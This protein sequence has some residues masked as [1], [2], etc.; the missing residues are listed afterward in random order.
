MQGGA[1][2][3]GRGSPAI[4]APCTNTES[5]IFEDRRLQRDAGKDSPCSSTDSAGISSCSGWFAA[6]V[7]GHSRELQVYPDFE[8]DDD[9]LFEEWKTTAVNHDNTHAFQTGL[10][11]GGSLFETRHRHD[12]FCFEV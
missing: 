6:A 9:V 2:N 11:G 10:W 5:A 3:R 8:G 1:G 12:E 7:L 4:E